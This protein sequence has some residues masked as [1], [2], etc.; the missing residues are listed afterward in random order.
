MG[1]MGWGGV[2][3]LGGV[4]VYAQSLSYVRTSANVNAKDGEAAEM[5]GKE[6]IKRKVCLKTRRSLSRRSGSNEIQQ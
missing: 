2:G 5:N 6:G 1:G 4:A 3:G